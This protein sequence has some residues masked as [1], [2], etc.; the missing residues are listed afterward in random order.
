M[1]DYF[2][3]HLLDEDQKLQ[4]LKK[5]LLRLPHLLLLKLNLGVHDVR[6]QKLR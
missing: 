1:V 3:L 6:H 4:R 2:Q 5:S